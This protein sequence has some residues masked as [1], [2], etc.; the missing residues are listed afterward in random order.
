[1]QDSNGCEASIRTTTNCNGCGISCSPSNATGTCASGT[2]QIASCNPGYGDCDSSPANGC[3][4]SLT[5]NS[6]CGSCGIAC[7]PPGGG[8]DCS[9]G[10]C[11]V[12]S[13]SPG[14]E[15]CDGNSANGCETNI[16]TLANCGD[17]GVTCSRDNATATCSSGSCADRKSVV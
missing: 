4:T 6:N 8:G 2:C 16:R 12:S 9:T 13:C 17:C 5:T 11:R 10:T 7:A 1:G 14:F 3:E 15:D